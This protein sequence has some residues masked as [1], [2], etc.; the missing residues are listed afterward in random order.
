MNK[1]E[2]IK[3]FFTEKELKKIDRLNKRYNKSCY[4]KKPKSK[5][6]Q[7]MLKRLN[8][9]FRKLDRIELPNLFNTGQVKPKR[10]KKKPNY[11]KYKFKKVKKV[12]VKEPKTILK[13]VSFYD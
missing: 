6:D 11:K 8:K 5:I 2:V 4:K 12:E 7:R 10:K 9:M 3:L 1:P 13:P